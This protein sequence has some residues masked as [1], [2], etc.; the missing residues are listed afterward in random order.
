MEK[1]IFV[2]RKIVV[3]EVS[4]VKLGEVVYV[5]ILVK[6]EDVKAIQTDNIDIKRILDNRRADYYFFWIRE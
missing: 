6:N 1:S 4:R 2:S 5:G 3:E